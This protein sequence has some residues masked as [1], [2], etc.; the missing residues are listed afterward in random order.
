MYADCFGF[1]EEEVF[2]ALDD[3]DMGDRKEI[4]KKWYD[5]FTLENI[6]IYTIR[7]LLQII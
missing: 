2:A 7:G 1:T 6:V 3:F 5:G 4:V